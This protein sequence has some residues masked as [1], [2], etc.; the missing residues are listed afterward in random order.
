PVT[1]DSNGNFTIIAHDNGDNSQRTETLI[2]SQKGLCKIV[3]CA[4]GCEYCFPNQQLVFPPC[5]SSDNRTVTVAG[6]SVRIKGLNLKGATMGGRYQI[7]FAVED[8]LGRM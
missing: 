1:T 3:S 5:N 6:L 7:G 4:S 2:Y 8:W